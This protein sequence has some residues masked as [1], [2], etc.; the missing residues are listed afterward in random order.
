MSPSLS[1]AGEPTTDEAIAEGL[2]EA[3]VRRVVHHFY[4]LV[5]ADPLIG[6]VF[7]ARIAEGHWPEH[8]EKITAFWS[9]ALLGTR[10]YSGKPM[11]KHQAIEE[12]EDAHF[13]RWLAIF[14]HTVTE[15]CPERTAALFIARSER[16]A[17]AFRMNIAMH[18][19]DILT[20]RPPL[21]REEFP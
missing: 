7:H 6:P 1:R 20:F 14:R 16:V 12:L 18:R 21:T 5:R 2:D 19:G 9:S 13:R 4:D 11:P 3:M 17:E 10:S 15:L 8:R